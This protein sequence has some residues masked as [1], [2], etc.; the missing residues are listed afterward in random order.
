MTR[1][2]RGR[3]RNEISPSALLASKLVSAAYGKEYAS[4]LAPR[5]RAYGDF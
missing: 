3:G 2:K 1:K 4:L 5:R